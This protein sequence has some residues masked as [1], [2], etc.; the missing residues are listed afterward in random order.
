MVTGQII[1]LV[2]LIIFSAFFSGVETALASINNIKANTLLKQK[3]RG[4]EA[5]YRLKQ[6][7]HKIIITILIM[8]NVINIG[9]AS[10]ATVAFTELLGSSG[11]G[12]A[13]GVMTFLVLVFGEITP[14]TLAVQ[15]AEA[16]S[17]VVARPIELLS[18]LLTPLV[19]FF[20]VIS[21]FMLKILGS[22]DAP[23]LSEEEVKTIV[24]MGAEQGV[25][26]K[27]AANIMQNVLEF[28][29][30]KVNEVMTPKNDM[31]MIDAD[32]KLKDVFEFIVKT[33]YSRYPI[34]SKRKDNIIGVI[35]VDDFLRE[36]K[37]NNLNKKIKSI[38]K[39]VI[40][41]PKAKK[42]NELL[43]ELEGKKIPMAIVVNEYGNLSGL[44]TTEDILEEIVGDI[45][46][47]SK[48]NRVFIKKVNKNLIKANARA[49]V[50][51]L[52]KE[53]HLGIKEGNFNTLSGF[54]LNK[55]G[56]IPKKGEEI[57]LDKVTLVIEKV[58]NKEIQ[59]VKIIKD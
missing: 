4:S 50:E 26:N 38:S 11:V 22:K 21:K 29:S 7:P 19:W 10:L 17:L 45:F 34:Y 47:K 59:K 33:P 48:R 16:I 13:T 44:V 14:K 54:I 56:R 46:D 18:K 43:N 1:T 15:N 3:K 24:T 52:N 30:T 53:L 40:F 25:L 23:G 5:L 27:E 55:I 9:A 51:M 41:V 49:S 12:I 32:K 42:I 8:N 31:S 36:V 2:V 57:K 37:K 20:G 6:D 35:D 28:E 39:N 58:T